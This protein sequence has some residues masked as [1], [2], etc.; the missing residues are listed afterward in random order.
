MPTEVNVI[1]YGGA[2]GGGKSYAL[3]MDSLKYIHD[4]KYRAVYFRQN[5]TQLEESLWPEAIELFTPFLTH[6]T[7]PLKGKYL[8]GARIRE[9]GHRIIFPS[10]ATLKFSYL[11]LDKHKK[12]YQGAQYTGI[13]FDE[14]TQFEFELFN[15]LRTRTRSA[16]DFPSFVRVSCNPDPFSWIKSWIDPF[17]DQDGYPILELSGKIRYFIFFDGQFFSS[18]DREQLLKNFPGK[19]T[20]SY[21]FIPSKLTDNKKLLEK[22]PDYDADLDANTKAEKAALLDGCWNYQLNEGSYFNRDWLIKAD[23]VPERAVPARAWDK[24]SSVP[25][26]TNKYPDYTA[27]VKMYKDTDGLYYLVGDCLPEIQDETEIAN[28][29]RK[30][31]GERD[32]LITKQAKEDGVECTV[33]FSKDPG[34]AGDSEF[35]QSAKKLIEIGM[36]VRPDPMPSNKTKVT[37]FSPFSSACQNGL[38]RIVPSTWKNQASLEHF[39]KE[40]ETFNGEPSSARR[41]DDLADSVAS[42]FNFLAQEQVIDIRGLQAGLSKIQPPPVGGFKNLTSI[43]DY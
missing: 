16:S 29:F 27:T 9:K 13:Y 43:M 2:A 11:E 7:G 21:T 8:S 3:L 1:F 39:L 12:T 36:V 30:L 34:Q 38:M 22:N 35:Q 32:A 26:D 33:V 40:L 15:Y 42:V 14:G 17:L 6:Q 24:A 25:S 20:R 10:G 31:P 41:K 18:W 4:P 5:T 37:R 19:K 28:R 23:R